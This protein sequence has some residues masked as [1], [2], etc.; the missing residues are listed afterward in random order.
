VRSTGTFENLR[1]TLA[2]SLR[3]K[4]YSKKLNAVNRRMDEVLDF[5]DEI[6]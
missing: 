1:I 2:N 6:L 3:G 4:F 5:E